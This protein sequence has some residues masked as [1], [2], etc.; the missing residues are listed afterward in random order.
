[1]KKVSFPSG[2]ALTTFP[3]LSGQATKQAA[4]LM[5]LLKIKNISPVIISYRLYR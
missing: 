5:F 1:M 3:L 4:S 2:Q